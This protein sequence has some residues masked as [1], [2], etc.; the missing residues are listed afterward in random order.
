MRWK[1]IQRTDPDRVSV[2]VDGDEVLVF[3]A[4]EDAYRFSDR[5]RYRAD[6]IGPS[7]AERCPDTCQVV[8]CEAQ[9]NWSL[10]GVPRQGGIARLCSTH[11]S[12][13]KRM[14]YDD[15]RWKQV[16]AWDPDE[17]PTHPGQEGL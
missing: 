8:D 3:E 4:P 14:A 9:A 1:I 16:T 5:L 6:G 15:D 2:Y 10:M 7:R 12:E 11:Y 13:Y 17:R